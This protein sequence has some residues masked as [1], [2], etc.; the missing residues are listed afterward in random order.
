M[1]DALAELI[2]E[3]AE[4]VRHAQR[5]SAGGRGDE[6]CD[7]GAADYLQR[8]KAAYR[9][10]TLRATPD[11]GDGWRTMESAPRDE[12]PFL[13]RYQWLGEHRYSVVH[14]NAKVALWVYDGSGYIVPSQILLTHW[15]PLPPPPA[16][17]AQGD[18]R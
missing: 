17:T 6:H 10:G 2:E 13:A 16:G 15:R 8:L 1:A 12:K 11:A 7:C 3:A 9:A 14:W 4:H 5:C 18:G